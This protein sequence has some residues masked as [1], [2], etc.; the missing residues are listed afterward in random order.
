MP[1]DRGVLDPNPMRLR[2]DPEAGVR[3]AGVRGPR[4]PEHPVRGR[5]LLDVGSVVA[6]KAL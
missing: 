4:E 3:V 2:T 1:R 5:V 6:E